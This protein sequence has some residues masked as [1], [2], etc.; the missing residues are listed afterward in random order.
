MGKRHEAPQGAQ[1]LW[2]MTIRQDTWSSDLLYRGALGW[3]AR[4]LRNGCSVWAIDR[5]TRSSAV[6]WS[7]S[8]RTFLGTSTDTSEAAGE[9]VGEPSGQQTP[10]DELDDSA[11]DDC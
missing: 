9:R 10:N 2:T 11:D 3:H 5:R 4:V 1:S 6:D 7:E 8:M